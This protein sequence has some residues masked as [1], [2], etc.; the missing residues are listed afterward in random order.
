MKSEIVANK[1]DKLNNNLTP[2]CSP[3]GARRSSHLW[4]DMMGVLRRKDSTATTQSV[5]IANAINNNRISC[6]TGGTSTSSQSRSP[7]ISILRHH[8]YYYSEVSHTSPTFSFNYQF[9]LKRDENERIFM[10]FLV[11][12][13]FLNPFNFASLHRHHIIFDEI[14]KYYFIHQID[15]DIP[16]K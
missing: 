5:A 8:R 7:S 11:Q 13:M 6:P 10:L 12:K 15:I 9:I 2:P 14:E 4:R 1:I 3:S 16:K